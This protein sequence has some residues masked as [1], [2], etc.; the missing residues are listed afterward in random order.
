MVQV[1]SKRKTACKSKQLNVSELARICVI[2]LGH[3][4]QVH[5]TFGNKILSHTHFTW[6]WD[7]VI[8]S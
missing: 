5:W 4:L 6:V 8:I 2:S 3:S 7:Y 1:L